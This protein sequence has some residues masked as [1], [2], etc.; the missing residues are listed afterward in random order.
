L[1]IFSFVLGI[2][3]KFEE[4]DLDDILRKRLKDSTEIPGALWHI[5]AGKDVDKIREFL[6]KVQFRLTDNLSSSA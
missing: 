3:K 1:K 6:Q 4:E 2:L 5:Y